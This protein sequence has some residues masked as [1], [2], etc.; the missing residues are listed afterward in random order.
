SA[1]R[2]VHYGYDLTPGSTGF[3]RGLLREVVRE[4]DDT[5]ALY[6]RTTTSRDERGVPTEVAQCDHAGSCRT[7]TY[8]YDADGIHV[9]TLTDAMNQTTT[10][11]WHPGLGVK[12]SETGVD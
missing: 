11:V 9:H 5:G 1:T 3:P 4:P 12:L 8:G 6:L 7:T 10:S 2:T